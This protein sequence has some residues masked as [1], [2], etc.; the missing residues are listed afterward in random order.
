MITINLG[1]AAFTYALLIGF[2]LLG[3]VRGFRYMVS[4]AIFL[5]IGYTL[6]VQGGGFI[7]GLVNRFWTQLPRLFGFL[8]GRSPAEIDPFDPLIP[9]NFE[10]PLLFRL[11][12]F[13]ALLLVG[14]VKAWPWE[15][16][17]LTGFKGGSQPMR[18]LGAASGVYIGVLGVS[19]V[20][21]FWN[22]LGRSLD[23]PEP[24]LVALNG[25]PTYADI[26]PSVI[27][28][29]L[30]LIIILIALQFPRVWRP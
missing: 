15:G 8:L 24:L 17:P 6:A 3:W 21:I 27:G 26:M 18:I 29:F 4:I 2:G 25:L 16:K 10:A 11:L 13:I 23:L 20:S 28:A 9:D 5:T 14:I 19:A 12:V 1:S 22:E 30:V 7:V